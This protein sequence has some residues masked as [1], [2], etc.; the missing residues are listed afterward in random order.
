[1]LWNIKKLGINLIEVHNYVVIKRFSPMGKYKL[2]T[3]WK[4]PF[5]IW[6]EILFS[7]RSILG[8]L[9]NTIFGVQI[10]VCI[11]YP[12]VISRIKYIGYLGKGVLVANL[13]SITEP[14][15]AQNR[16]VRSCVRKWW[17]CNSFQGFYHMP[18]IWAA[19]CQ[20]QQSGMCAQWR[21]RS[22]WASAQADQS[23]RCALSV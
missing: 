13:G 14:F 7:N 11:S 19:A 17:R 3:L 16:V 22:A 18:L 5:Q 9:Y 21:L 23:L 6:E 2:A 10:Q 20:N 8:T 12:S 4:R 15:Y 1:M